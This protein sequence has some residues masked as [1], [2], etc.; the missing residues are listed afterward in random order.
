MFFDEV[1]Q[2]PTRYGIANTRD[3]CAG[4][5]LFGEDATPCPAPDAYFYYHEGHPSSAVQRIV[6]ERLQHEIAELFPQ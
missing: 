1:F 3:R 5:A 4:R 6:A 2:K